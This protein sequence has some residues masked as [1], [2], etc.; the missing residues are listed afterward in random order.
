MTDKTRTDVLLTEDDPADAGPHRADRALCR[1]KEMG[2]N[3]VVA[4]A[5]ALVPARRA[6]P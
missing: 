4:D 2:R 5:P 6:V 3:R 1:A